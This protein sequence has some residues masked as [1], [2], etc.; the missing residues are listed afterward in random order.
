[1]AKTPSTSREQWLNDFA[2]AAAPRFEELGS[3]LPKETCLACG[4]GQLGVK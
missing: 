3:P 4:D 1:M 2:K